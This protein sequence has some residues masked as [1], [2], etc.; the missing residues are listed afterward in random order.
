MALNA[1][2]S[3]ESLLDIEMSL[4]VGYILQRFTDRDFRI[5]LVF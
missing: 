5:N 4:S 1:S 2:N 3:D